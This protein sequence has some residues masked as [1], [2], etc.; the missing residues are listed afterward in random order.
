MLGPPQLLSL[1]PPVLLLSAPIPVIT[2]WVEHSTSDYF[3]QS[4]PL[5]QHDTNKLTQ[6]GCTSAVQ[7]NGSDQLRCRCEWE[8]ATTSPEEH[9]TVCACVCETLLMCVFHLFWCIPVIINKFHL[10]DNI[11]RCRLFIHLCLLHLL[12]CFN[13]L[14]IICMHACHMLG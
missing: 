2:L 10:Y 9:W 14:I 5:R 13:A 12:L 7:L 8:V 6:L 11:Y 4:E 3:Y 1:A